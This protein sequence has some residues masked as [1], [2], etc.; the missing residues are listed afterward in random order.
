MFDV[1]RFA[2]LIRAVYGSL[3]HIQSLQMLQDN[4]ADAFDVAFFS[5]SL[6]VT[7]LDLNRVGKFVDIHG[8]FAGFIQKKVEVEI[9]AGHHAVVV[10]S[11]VG[12]RDGAVVERRGVAVGVGMVSVIVVVMVGGDGSGRRC[13]QHG[14][15]IGRDVVHQHLQD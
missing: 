14:D 5:H 9:V 2:F 13:W 8:V 1:Q 6:Q 4:V 3:R 7:Q 10:G 12:L 11:G 15:S